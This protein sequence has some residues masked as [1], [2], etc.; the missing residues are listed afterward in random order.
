MAASTP[1]TILLKPNG[2][3]YAE[4]SVFE[5]TVVS[6]DITPGEFVIFSSGSVRPH[7]VAADVDAPNILAVEN[8]YLDPRVST[9]NPID[10][11]YAVAAKAKLIFPQT[12]D[13]CY[14]FLE[15]AANVAKGAPLEHNGSGHLQAYSTGKIVAYAAEA[16]DNSGGGSSVRIKVWIA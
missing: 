7:N 15:A 14:C 10:T 1:S 2:G 8:A 16:K 9:S 6:A 11:D 12:G 5:E 13:L 4:R 3:P